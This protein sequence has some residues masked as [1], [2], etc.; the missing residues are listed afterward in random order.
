MIM[1]CLVYL[2]AALQLQRIQSVQIGTGN[3]WKRGKL[4]ISFGSSLVNG[5][6]KGVDE[7]RAV[8]MEYASA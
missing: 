8:P 6:G 1:Q 2:A 3:R 7:K 4:H 5:Q